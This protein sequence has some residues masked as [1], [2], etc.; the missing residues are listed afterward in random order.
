[1]SGWTAISRRRFLAGL[2]AT[3]IL[4]ACGGGGGD[5]GE[6]GDEEAV[7]PSSTTTTA[8]PPVLPLSGLAHLGDPA[9]LTRPALVV[10]IDNAEGSGRARPQAGLNAADVVYEERVEGSVTRLAAVFQ[11]QD[12]DPVGPIRSFRTTDL[13]IVANL[14]NPLLAWSGANRVFA[15]LARNGPLVDVGYDVATEAYYRESERS[16]PHNLMSSTP[17]LRAYTP[18]GAGPPPPLFTYRAPGTPPAGGR[19]VADVHISFGGGGGAAPV[20]YRVDPATGTWLRFQRD[21]PHVDEAGVQVQPENVVVMHVDYVDT[22]AVDSTGGPVPEAQLVGSGLVWVLTGG[23]L[24]EGTWNR[25]S[26]EATATLA[27]AAG[28]PIGLTPG[29]TWVALPEP[30]GATVVA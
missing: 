30:G 3:P 11:S 18:E 29:R 17:A 7:V 4:A 1:M 19:P 10:K 23:T 5:E 12:A 22:G 8:P 20:N 21:T 27:D 16:A 25:P 6:G 24:I 26:L 28:A 14:N 2:A 15:E 9:V 13:A